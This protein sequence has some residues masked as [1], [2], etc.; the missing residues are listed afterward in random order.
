[1]KTSVQ[2]GPFGLKM[3]LDSFLELLQEQYAEALTSNDREGLIQTSGVLAIT[4]AGLDRPEL[5]RRW[6]EQYLSMLDVTTNERG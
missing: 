1:M 4:Y 6:A 2:G 3:E 5:A